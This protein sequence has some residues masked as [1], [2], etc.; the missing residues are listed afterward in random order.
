MVYLIFAHLN[1]S[2]PVEYKLNSLRAGALS[3]LFTALAPC[4]VRSLA[5]GRW[6]DKS[7]Y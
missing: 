1:V 2:S 6:K 4:L 7:V 5:Y 3:V